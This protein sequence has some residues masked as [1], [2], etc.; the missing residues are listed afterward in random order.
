MNDEQCLWYHGTSLENLISIMT[1]GFRAG[2]WFAR[3]MEDAFT[4]GGEVCGFCCGRV[5]RHSDGMAGVLTES[6][7][8]VFD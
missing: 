7:P 3:H 5:C 1:T 4:F 2:T 8:R 6:Y